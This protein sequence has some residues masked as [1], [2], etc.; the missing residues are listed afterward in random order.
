[1]KIVQANKKLNTGK[2]KKENKILENEYLKLNK[3]YVIFSK[4]QKKRILIDFVKKY[5]KL[6]KENTELKKKLS[7]F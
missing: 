7:L 3:D 6:N 2:S 4:K 1:M 5:D